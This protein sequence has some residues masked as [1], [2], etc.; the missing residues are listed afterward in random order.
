MIAALVLTVI[1]V[2]DCPATWILFDAC[3]TSLELRVLSPYCIIIHS[4]RFLFFFQHD[5]NF[6]YFYHT[7]FRCEYT[8]ITLTSK[9]D[10]T[11]CSR[12]RFKFLTF[13]FSTKYTIIC[14]QHVCKTSIYILMLWSAV[15]A[16]YKNF[17]GIYHI[18]FRCE[19]THIALTSKS[20]PTNCS[21]YL[22]KFLTFFFST[23]CTIIICYQRVSVYAPY[24][25][26]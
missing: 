1:T 6:R 9:P 19:Y 21:R 10:P 16:P 2:D 24:N 23:K 14:Y 15:Y 20:D 17:R 7:L 13:S 12:Y 18:P 5:M 11:N 3:S 22:F 25:T 26:R 4:K 8:H